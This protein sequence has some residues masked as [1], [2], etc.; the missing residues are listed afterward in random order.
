MSLIKKIKKLFFPPPLKGAEEAF[1]LKDNKNYA[2]YNVGIGS[3]GKPRVHDW[4]D[5][6]NLTIGKYCSIAKNVHI[7]LGGEH[8]SDWVTTYPFMALTNEASHLELDKKSKGSVSIG[9]DVWI[10]MNSIILSGV[11]IGN[12][13]IIGAG[14]VVTK[15]VP[16]YSIYAGNPAKLIRLRFSEEMIIALNE[17]AWWNWDEKKIIDNYEFLLTKNVAEFIIK[18]KK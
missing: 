15:D 3:Y 17:I 6:T 10:G 12:G 2:N 18:H 4:K 5:E 9:S 16:S 11:N 8:H 1:Y 7:L 13:A 14:S